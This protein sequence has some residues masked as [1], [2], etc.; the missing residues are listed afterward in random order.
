M[1]TDTGLR[2]VGE[3]T[4]VIRKM[5]EELGNMSYDRDP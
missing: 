3:A 5:R 2:V 4:A 1:M